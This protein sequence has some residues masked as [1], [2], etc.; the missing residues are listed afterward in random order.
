MAGLHYDLS[1]PKHLHPQLIANLDNAIDAAYKAV[2]DGG[3][4][5]ASMTFTIG[6]TYDEEKGLEAELTIKHL[7]THKAHF[8]PNRGGQMS[9]LEE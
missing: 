6:F 5:K 2:E 4:H 8:T 1:K 7:T 3:N 9:M